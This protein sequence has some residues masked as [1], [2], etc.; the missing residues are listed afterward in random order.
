[1]SFRGSSAT[2]PVMETDMCTAFTHITELVIETVTIPTFIEQV[3]QVAAS[4][5]L[6]ETLIAVAEYT[7]NSDLA[8]AL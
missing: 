8:V 3:A 2:S 7:H 6:Q 1:M 5:T 4:F